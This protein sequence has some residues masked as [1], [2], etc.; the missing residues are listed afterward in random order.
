MSNKNIQIKPPDNSYGDVLHPETNAGQVLIADTANKFAASTVEAAL[1]ELFTLASD[2]KTAV[3]NAITAKGVSASSADT[4]ST[5]ATKVG[6]IPKAQ[7][8]A[9]ETYVLSGQTFTN[10]D[11][12]LRTGT[13]TNY[14][15]AVV[16]STYERI[17]ELIPHPSDPNGQGRLTTTVPITGYINSS[18]QLQIN[19]ANLIPSNIKAGT[20][21]GKYQGAGSQVIV[22]T[23][24]SDANAVASQI[25]NG[26]TAYVNGVKITGTAPNYT[27]GVN[28]SASSAWS[29]GAGVIG[30]SPPSG[31]FFNGGGVYVTDSNFIGSSVRSGITLFGL[32]SGTAPNITY[33]TSA[34]SGGYDG[35]T[36][37]V[38]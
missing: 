24:T 36:W 9:T 6:Q 4:F 7:G 34:P 33:S 19:I 15:G 29:S 5:L 3:A 8:G 2:G 18:T 20:A 35:D 14:N 27:N 11:G 28:Y 32:V 23:F 31:S 38:Q 17:S 37:V 12:T 26:Y 30:I 10:A 16:G 21:V 1:L 25:V 13:M 22:G